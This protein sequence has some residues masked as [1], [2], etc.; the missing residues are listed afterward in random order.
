MDFEITSSLD[1]DILVVT[2][3]GQ[4]TAE[5]VQAMTARYFDIALGSGLRKILADIRLLNGRLSAGEI[6]FLVRDLPVKPIP[7]GIKTALLEA[8]ERRDFANF[9][10]TTSA[11]AGVPL[12]CFFDRGEAVAWLRGP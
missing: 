12:K 6:Y 5:N 1:G 10:E 11:N 8:K 2:F 9:L 4:S 3:A 7:P